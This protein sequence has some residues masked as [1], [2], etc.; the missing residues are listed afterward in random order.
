MNGYFCKYL[1]GED[2][3]DDGY[4]DAD[5]AAVTLKL[6]ECVWIEEELSDDEVWAG[7]HFLPQVHQVLLVTHA[8]RV[9]RRVA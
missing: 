1:D 3:G 7:V 9:T 5:G 2:A 8:V 4:S 6:E